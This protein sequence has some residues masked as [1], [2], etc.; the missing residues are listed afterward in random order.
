MDAR[1]IRGFRIFARQH[2]PMELS[3]S[4]KTAL[5]CGASSGIGLASAVE[6]SLLGATCILMARNEKKLASALGKLRGQGHSCL[7]ADFNYPEQVK[8][9]V[10]SIER[11]VHVLVNNTGG[12]PPGPVGEASPAAFLAAMQRH[13]VCNQI[14]AQAV[15]PGMASEGYGRIINI[16]STSVKAP[17]PGLGVSNSARWAVAAWAKTLA[18]EV[19]P[20]S[21]TVNNVLPGSTMTGRLKALLEEKAARQ[22][23]AYEK[24]EKEELKQIPMGRFAKAEET[25]A[26]VAFLA[27]PAAS[28]ITGT[29]IQVD[30]GKTPVL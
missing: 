2:L 1:T 23:L 6:L 3:L 30:G 4:G 22:G 29:A 25:A 12:P 7:V 10:A 17:I 18:A 11:T 19:A 14:L 16:V 26:L 8:E 28:Y 24:V 9:A 13:L 21:I 27:S 15:I 20:R 5:V